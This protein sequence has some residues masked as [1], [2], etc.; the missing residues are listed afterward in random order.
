MLTKAYPDEKASPVRPDTLAEGTHTGVMHLVP[1]RAAHR[2]LPHAQSGRPV[3]SQKRDPPRRSHGNC[4]HDA[5]APSLTAH[6]E[7]AV[8][9]DNRTDKKVGQQ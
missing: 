9:D 2:A 7:C 8:N 5:P 4:H 6:G 1:S 3:R